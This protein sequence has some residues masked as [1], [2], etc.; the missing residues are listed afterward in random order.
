MKDMNEYNNAK[1]INRII[2]CSKLSSEIFGH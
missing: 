2:E 1:R